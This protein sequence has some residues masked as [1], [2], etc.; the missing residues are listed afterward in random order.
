MSKP[1]ASV[2][3]ASSGKDL[4]LGFCAQVGQSKK[5]DPVGT[6]VP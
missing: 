2:T 4:A 1:F 5:D 3:G 6:R